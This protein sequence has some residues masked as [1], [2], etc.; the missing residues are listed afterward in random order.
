MKVSFDR[1]EELGLYK[2]PEPELS[3]LDILSDNFKRIRIPRFH[4]DW[5]SLPRWMREG[6]VASMAMSVICLAGVLGIRSLGPPGREPSGEP[7]VMM[8]SQTEN[9]YIGSQNTSGITVKELTM[10]GR[11]AEVFEEA[12][13][14]EIT[15]N[16][17]VTSGMVDVVQLPTEQLQEFLSAG[18]PA[19][20]ADQELSDTEQAEGEIIQEAED[21]EQNPDEQENNPEDGQSSDGMGTEEQ[22]SDESE[23]ESGEDEESDDSEEDNSEDDSEDNSEEDDSEED[24][25]EEDDSEEDNS[26]EDNSEEDSEEDD[27]EENDSEEEEEPEPE[28]EPEIVVANVKNQLNV[29][30][31]PSKDAELAGTLY[32]DC[33]G[34]VL[35]QEDG[36]TKIES[37]N[38]IGWASDDYLLFG[39]EAQEVV[40]ETGIAVA[41]IET[42]NLRVRQE[43]ATGDVIG[44][45]SEGDE[46]EI[47]ETVEVDDTEWIE[48]EFNG[49]KAY[50]STDFVTVK[51][52]VNTGDTVEEMKAKA[53]EKA[54]E[55]AEESKKKK[56]S[57]TDVELTITEAYDGDASELELLATIIYCEAGNQSYEGKVAV[58]NVV[59]NR[60][61]SASFPND[62]NAVIRSPRQFSPVGSGKFDRV[63]GSGRVPESCYEAAQDAMNGIS[64]VGDCL[65]FKNPKIA[66]A[67]SGITIGDHVFW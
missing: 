46:L 23:D 44:H 22:E 1:L 16:T 34:V 8:A 27:S 61:A 38:L 11:R 21:P 39:D 59:L 40:E 12:T 35:E 5:Y 19:G 55:A 18:E 3:R 31:E 66:G 64:F 32:K 25:S 67:H 57:D 48:I 56:S 36:W 6:A 49:K 50:I 17:A 42:E 29:R 52:Q 30:V 45:I 43:P 26:E 28:P 41:K 15:D 65:Y 37:G 10:Q 24:N 62:I 7:E 13:A 53:E 51:M 54:K 60:R 14:D 20:E 58:G 47:L 63:L 2:P 33:G 4:L 9:A